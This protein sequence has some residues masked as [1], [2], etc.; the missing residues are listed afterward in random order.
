MNHAAIIQEESTM[1]NKFELEQQLIDFW[2]IT[3]E[4]D[5]IESQGITEADRNEL[6]RVYESKF[7]RLW[8]NFNTMVAEGQFEHSK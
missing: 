6:I 8:D 4:I 1:P 3:D 2:K 7:N 5:R